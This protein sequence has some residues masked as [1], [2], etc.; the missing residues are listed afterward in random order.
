MKSWKIAILFFI[1]GQTTSVGQSAKP[2]KAEKKQELKNIDSLFI[3]YS[4]PITVET[5]SA[6]FNVQLK[7]SIIEI[8]KNK[9]Y[10]CPGYPIVGNLITE[11]MFDFLPSPVTDSERYLEIMGKA[12]KDRSYYFGLM[13]L[14][15]PF[16]QSVTLSSEINDAGMSFIIVKRQNFPNGRK[17]RIWTFKYDESEPVNSLAMRII[18][19]LIN[20][21]PLQ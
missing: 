12:A 6:V 10:Q 14:A 9:K 16:L 4:L 20:T 3:V 19:V 8:L 13:E 17:S 11:K 2:T 1:F 18:D 7:D 21:S 15:D 5:T